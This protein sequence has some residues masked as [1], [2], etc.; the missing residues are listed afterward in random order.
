MPEPTA[1]VTLL[2]LRLSE[3]GVL[4][5]S[6]AGVAYAF[7]WPADADTDNDTDTDT[8]TDTETLRRLLDASAV[9][10]AL[11]EGALQRTRVD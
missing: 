6:S 1:S 4:A 9:P 10:L 3:Q 7:D 5:L 11:L 8:D 2:D